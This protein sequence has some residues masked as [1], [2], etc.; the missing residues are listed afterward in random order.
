MNQLNMFYNTINADEDQAYSFAHRNKTQ[1]E[2][3]LY[4]FQLIGRPLTPFEVHAYYVYNFGNA[5]ITS[6]RRAITTLTYQ[7]KLKKTGE[8]KPGGYDVPNYKWKINA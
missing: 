4:L 6:I 8:K 2:K 7:N 5:P 3:V 1:N